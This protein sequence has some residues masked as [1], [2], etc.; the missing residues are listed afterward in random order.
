M[1]ELLRILVDE[2]MLSW[3]KSWKIVYNTFSYTNHTV[4]PEALEKWS[5]KLLGKL[6]PR[7]LDL[8]YL[9]N[10]FW[11]EKIEKKYPGDGERKGRMSIIEEGEPKKVRMA[12]LCIVCSHAVNGVAYL[13]SQ[14]LKETIFKDFH[15]MWPTKL[16]NKTNGVTPRR[17]LH[18]CNPE[19]SRLLTDTLG[20]NEWI[21]ELDVLRDMKGHAVSPEMQKKWQEVKRQRKQIFADWIF[22]R[23]K[24]KVSID[25][26][27]DVQ[28]KRI[29]EYKRQ[30]MNI[31][32]VIHRY[33]QI[34]D[35]PKADRKDKVSFFKSNVL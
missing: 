27:F 17:W 21:S 20:D 5:V 9:I 1:V 18:C 2:E 31:L 24:I 16:Q 10:W 8:I 26:L 25:A 4:L 35:T 6:L 3:E 33:F 19:L 22:D 12:Y 11:M 34:K 15:E 23:C 13:H 30:T 32:Y 28:V 29:H 14:L 7:H